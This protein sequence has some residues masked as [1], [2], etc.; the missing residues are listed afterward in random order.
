MRPRIPTCSIT[1][2]QGS[3]LP[4]ST[5]CG[6]IMLPKSNLRLIFIMQEQSEP[7]LGIVDCNNLGES[8]TFHVKVVTRISIR[9]DDLE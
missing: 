7:Y 1:Q 9:L 3:P 5:E 2:I 6:H 8:R 4:V